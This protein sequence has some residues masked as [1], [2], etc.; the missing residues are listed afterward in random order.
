MLLATTFRCGVRETEVALA[1]RIYRHYRSGLR[2][3]NVVASSFGVS[4][5]ERV[6]RRASAFCE[7]AWKGMSGD[8]CRVS[9]TGVIGSGHAL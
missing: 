4:G 9:G 5:N 2:D 6:A 3:A 1:M 7:H 8:W